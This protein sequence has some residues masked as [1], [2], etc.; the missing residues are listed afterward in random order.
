MTLD[1]QDSSTSLGRLNTPS[2]SDDRRLSG[3]LNLSR[4]SCDSQTAADSPRSPDSLSASR[5]DVPDY[6]NALRQ[7]HGAEAGM[8]TH[9]GSGEPIVSTNT[10]TSLAS[11]ASRL[12]D[13]EVIFED[14]DPE[15]PQNWSLLYRSW[16]I[17]CVSYST[18]VI[19]MYSTSYTATVPGL[20]QDFGVSKTTVTLGLTTY[21]LGL[22][23]GALVLAPMSELYGRRIIYLVCVVIWAALIIPCGLASSLTSII[24]VRYFG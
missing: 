17:F 20:M 5:L 9:E 16:I 19:I 22:A 2:L 12:P 18:W 8:D 3:S 4:C 1:A 6:P 24:I 23:S 7:Q 21:L 11:I 10:H 13:F 15:N 14:G